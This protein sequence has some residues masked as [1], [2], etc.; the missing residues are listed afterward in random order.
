MLQGQ[1]GHDVGQGLGRICRLAD[2]AT[3]HQV[4]GAGIQG[5]ARGEDPPLVVLG[6]ARRANPCLLY[7]SDAAD[8]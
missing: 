8:E 4:I 3:D 5:L 7:T 6:A 2:G 1:F